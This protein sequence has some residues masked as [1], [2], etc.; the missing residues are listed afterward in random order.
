MKSAT[1][2]KPI[3][4]VKNL[5]EQLSVTCQDK[6]TRNELEPFLQLMIDPQYLNSH[7]SLIRLYTCNNL[8]S[9]FKF[10][11]P[12]SPY[13]MELGRIF[14]A[15]VDSWKWLGDP[16]HV[17]F[18]LSCTLL[19][20]VA[21]FRSMVL[22]WEIDDS[23]KLVSR[24]LKVF[25]STV[26]HNHND[27][28]YEHMVSIIFSVFDE[29]GHIESEWMDVV[30]QALV[31]K[32]E[33]KQRLATQLI[34]R[35]SSRINNVIRHYFSTVEKEPVGKSKFKFDVIVQMYRISPDLISNLLD[36]FERI[37]EH[38]TVD[39]RIETMLS[40]EKLLLYKPINKEL[41]D[42]LSRKRFDKSVSVRIIWID[43]IGRIQQGQMG[44]IQCWI[45]DAINSHQQDKLVDLD[46]RVRIHQLKMLNNLYTRINH[47]GMFSSLVFD[48][49]IQSIMD[50]CRDRKE[51]V[52]REAINLCFHIL[53]DHLDGNYTICHNLEEKLIELVLVPDTDDC[54]TDHV[55]KLTE[56]VL[57]RILEK[58][59]VYEKR[60]AFDNNLTRQ[61]N[62]LGYVARSSPLH[63]GNIPKPTLY[64]INKTLFEWTKDNED[65]AISTPLQ[66]SIVGLMV[67]R[68]IGYQFL[69][70]K[71][72][73][74]LE[75]LEAMKLHCKQ[76][77]CKTIQHKH[78]F[79]SSSWNNLAK[80]V[81]L[82]KNNKTMD[83][84]VL[85]LVDTFVSNQRKSELR[86]IREWLLDQIGIG[87]IHPVYQTLV[88]FIEFE[89]GK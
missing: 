10:C 66:N 78:T 27:K 43:I 88:S 63:F 44:N 22:V 75:T 5:H 64:F 73:V 85:D 68:I 76:L 6:V 19:E 4:I 69:V 81:S 87:N 47:L 36:L 60:D 83:R 33:Q 29:C 49:T 51:L 14:T 35:S 74:G 65:V 1:T 38:S 77:I 89:C 17:L 7:D 26:Q 52:Q 53:N 71:M 3:E 15:F 56:K 42:M 9:I 2:T 79:S 57:D 58:I 24:L 41:W 40:I 21:T 62:L 31:D 54:Y 23:S 59:Q 12:R 72:G 20:S 30:F 39:I 80:L 86:Q 16:N 67:S 48:D 37:L 28:V 50:R 13:S 11:A 45:L 34:N 55:D 84:N 70:A 25:F 18:H 61:I 82:D 46:E 32:T 8:A